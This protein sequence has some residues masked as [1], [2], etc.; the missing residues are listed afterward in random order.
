MLYFPETLLSSSG[1]RLVA[2]ATGLTFLAASA[3]WLSV[4]VAT[5]IARVLTNPSPQTPTIPDE[6]HPDEWHPFQQAP[7][8]AIA[9]NVH[10]EITHWNPSA[11]QV[12]GY[13]PQEAMGR[14]AALIVPSHIKAY[15]NQVW[16]DL[17]N[18]RG[19]TRSINENV[20]QDGRT[21]ICEWFNA[22]LLDAQ[23][24]VLGAISFVQ[25]ITERTQVEK[26]LLQSA[27]FDSLTGLPNRAFFSDRLHQAAAKVS[28]QSDGCFAVLFLDLDRFKVVNDSLGHL[29]GD[30][31]LVEVAQRLQA[32]LRIGDTLAHLA[33]DEFAILLEHIQDINDATCVARQI[34][35]A[36][37]MPFILNGHEVFT[38]ISIGIALS[39]IDYEKPDNLL[40]DADT[41]MY[42]AKAL[43]KA[44]YEVFTLAM[45][46]HAVT[47]LQLE[48]DLRRAIQRQEFLV[49]YQ[50]IVSLRNSKV[51]GF[52][53]LVRWQHA[54]RGLIS[55]AEFI[56]VAE[57]TNLIVPIGWWVL[58]AACQQMRSWQLQFPTTAT[59]TMS[60][61]LSGKQIAQPDLVERIRQILTAT[62]LSPRN[63]KL[64][65][66]ES[67][68]MQNPEAT[69]ALFLQLQALGIR[70]SIDDFGTGYSSLAYLHHFPID[71]LKIDRSFVTSVDT[72]AEKLAIIRTI[73]TLA[74]N[75]GMDVIAE[76]VE[77]AKQLAQLKALK[78]E[79][80]QG[81]LFAKPMS[82]EAATA[83]IQ[84]HCYRVTR[85]S[86]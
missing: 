26:Q 5:A 41:A 65:I 49:H 83:F 74:W 15:A 40:R 69:T 48:N 12:F 79:A 77:T 17:I 76:G 62:G 13:S 19:G 61:N 18:Q 64:E 27:F 60:V 20:T 30:Q 59:W 28:R 44:R 7:L 42:R 35:E 53:A 66:T 75:L 10:G 72:D 39:T 81:Y 63:L 21:I 4:R 45:H 16:H 50:P 71:T 70:L 82:G 58:E 80:G 29:V 38:T 57:E 34:Q 23:G 9:W 47:L 25:D 8:A 24:Q 51:I 52:E 1:G 54:T 68:L 67:V 43:G 14:Q 11:A 33:G 3:R 31:L 56:P 36:I 32:C 86:S 78:C 85:K 37:K 2:L 84:A 46:D 22:P 55:P 73:V 6:W